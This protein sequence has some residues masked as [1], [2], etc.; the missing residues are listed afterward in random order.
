MEGTSSNIVG[1][2]IVFEPLTKENYDYWSCLVRNYLLGQGL[3]GFVTSI[4]ESTGPRSRRETEVWNRRN[5]K[6]LHII[7]LACGPENI[8]RIK[9][10]QSAREAWNELSAHYSSDLS[11]DPDIEQGICQFNADFFL[12]GKYYYTS[13]PQDVR[14]GRNKIQMVPH[15]DGTS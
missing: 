6:A 11:A 1:N 10:L 5:G 9:D 8:S 7:Q 15:I 13:S 12:I 3:W 14:Y 4:S 2:A